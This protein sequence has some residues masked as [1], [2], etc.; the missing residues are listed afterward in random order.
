MCKLPPQ[1]LT[2]T[3]HTSPSPPPTTRGRALPRGGL[4]GAKPQSWRRLG[5]LGSDTR[6]E[7]GGMSTN[8]EG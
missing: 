1:A 2:H 8:T 5:D 4:L 6:E 7:N 3:S